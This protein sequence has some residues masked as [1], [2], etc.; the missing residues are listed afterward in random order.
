[1]L[2]LQETWNKIWLW[3]SITANENLKENVKRRRSKAQIFIHVR[4]VIKTLSG[5]RYNCYFDT[6]KINW[7]LLASTKNVNLNITKIKQ[8]IF[9][10]HLDYKLCK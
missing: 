3:S 8:L 2:R 4:K 10:N 6:I 7:S 9:L 1:M 5:S